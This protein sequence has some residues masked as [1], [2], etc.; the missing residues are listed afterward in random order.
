MPGEKFLLLTQCLQLVISLIYCHWA[1]L[2]N[3]WLVQKQPLRVSPLEYLEVTVEKGFKRFELPFRRDLLL[4]VI[5]RVNQVI[6]D[7]LRYNLR[8]RVSVLINDLLNAVILGKAR[9]HHE[10]EFAHQEQ[11]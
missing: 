6:Y 3:V 7:L 5:S 10:L 2:G 8:R 4:A 1:Q 11:L 9:P